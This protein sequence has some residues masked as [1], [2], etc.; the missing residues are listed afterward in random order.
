MLFLSLFEIVLNKSIYLNINRKW[1]YTSLSPSSKQVY[2]EN[3]CTSTLITVRY[4]KL[5]SDKWSLWYIFLP[6]F[7]PWGSSVDSTLIT[8]APSRYLLL[9]MLIIFS[10]FTWKLLFISSCYNIFFKVK[11]RDQN[12]VR[13]ICKYVEDGKIMEELFKIFLNVT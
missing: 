2:F 7:L 10:H 3:T 9:S 8:L 12:Y 5:N 4:I 11:K 1:T 6:L 13:Y